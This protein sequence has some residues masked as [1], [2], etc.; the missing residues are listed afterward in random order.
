MGAIYILLGVGALIGA[1]NMAGTIPTV[2]YYGVGLLNE[3][4]VL[5]GHGH[6]LRPGRARHRQLVDHRRDPGRRLRGAG[7]AGRRRSRDRRRRRHLRR[8]LRRQD[9]ADLRDD[10]AGAVDGRQRDHQR[11]HRRDALDLGAGRG[12]SRSSGS[13][14]SGCWPA[15]GDRP[16]IPP[17]ARRSLAS[18]FKISLL[19][20]LPM[21]FLSSSRSAAS[22]PFLAIF[23]SALF[24]AVMAV[25]TQPAAVEAFVGDPTRGPGRTALEAIY[26]AMATGFVSQHRQREI[27]ALFSRGGMASM[28]NTIW[29]V[30]GALSLRRDHGGRR[31]PR[32]PGPPDRDQRQVDGSLIASVIGT[33]IGL[34]IIAGDQYVAIVMP[35]RV[36]RFEFAQA[37]DRPADAVAGGRGL[38]DGDLAAGAVE[39]LRRLHGRRAGG[40]HRGLP[41][42]LLLQPAQPGDLAVLRLHRL[43]HRARRTGR[44]ACPVATGSGRRPV[45]AQEGVAA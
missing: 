22:P 9:D 23:A 34:N 13:R 6:H 21:V 20:L 14:F 39:Q 2:V 35:S 30:L 16:S 32:A 45:E 26:G 4:V 29:L 19:N 3:H 36:Y 8:L 10:G 42:V 37:R 18:E 27:D 41:A 44:P 40:G 33:C 31:L 25:F 24:A 1:W 15:A 43:P 28:L 17:T 5:P 12:A 7:A 11:A 38:G